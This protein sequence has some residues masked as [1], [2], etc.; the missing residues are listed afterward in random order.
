MAGVQCVDSV[1]SEMHQTIM[2][3]TFQVWIYWMLN[4]ECIKWSKWGICIKNPLIAILKGNHILDT[5]KHMHI[6]RNEE[7]NSILC[8]LQSIQCLH[9]SS[10]CT[11]I[12]WTN[13]K[14]KSTWIEALLKFI[15][16]IKLLKT[17]KEKWIDVDDDA[18]EKIEIK[19]NVKDVVLRLMTL[20]F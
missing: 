17:E 5:H 15:L 4:S 16:H 12:Y 11:D 1:I 20:Y 19:S 6:E 18:F 14:S 9:T 7:I 8:L 10:I 3:N 2:S 13:E